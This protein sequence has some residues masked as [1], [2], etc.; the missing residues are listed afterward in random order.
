MATQTETVQ[1]LIPAWIPFRGL[2]L[3]IARRRCY[4]RLHAAFNGMTDDE[5]H[6]LGLERHHIGSLAR[7][8]AARIRF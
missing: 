5:L 6:R 7:A 4:L 1:S 2:R 8:G 3:L